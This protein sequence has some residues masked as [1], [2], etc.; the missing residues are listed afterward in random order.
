MATAADSWLT[1]MDRLLTLGD[2]RAAEK[3]C[4][5]TKMIQLVDIYYDALDAPK[6]GKKVTVPNELRVE[7][8]PHHMGRDADD[9][10]NSISVLGQIY[11]M[12]KEFKTEAVK[13]KEIWKLPCL[14]VPVPEL[15]DIWKARY[16]NYCKEM[17]KA[18]NLNDETKNDAANEVVKKYKHMSKMQLLYEAPDME[19]SPKDSEVIY[20]E[21][22]AIY[23]VTYD[24]AMSQG[25]EKCGFVWR[26]AGSALCSL[27]AW[28]LAGPKEKPI[29]ILPSVLHDLLN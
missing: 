22:I 17:A 5:K 18:M 13:E 24:Y 29:V 2:D 21:A 26:V 11:D 10:Y 20:D 16:K 27:C 15:Y 8:F 3:T 12:V 14:D 6:S 19:E 1:Y 4:L 25:I 28:K 9:S 7:D 23:H